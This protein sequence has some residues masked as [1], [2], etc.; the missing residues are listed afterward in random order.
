MKHLDFDLRLVR[1]QGVGVSNPLSPTMTLGSKHAA[2]TM[3]WAVIVF[4]P[5]GRFATALLPS[6]DL[7]DPL[8]FPLFR[9]CRSLLRRGLRGIALALR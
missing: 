6:A 9:L 4:R 5:K 7:L 3:V 2:H 1:D 8:A